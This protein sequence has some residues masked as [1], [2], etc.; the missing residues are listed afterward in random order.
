MDGRLL[1]AAEY[2]G[3]M[4]ESNPKADGRKGASNCTDSDLELRMVFGVRQS[5]FGFPGGP[6]FGGACAAR[7][8]LLGRR[9]SRL[10]DPPRIP[11]QSGIPVQIHTVY[12]VAFHRV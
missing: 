10:R 9:P 4:A 2:R 5:G 12:R 8:D 7:G 11:D 6:A 1:P 3:P